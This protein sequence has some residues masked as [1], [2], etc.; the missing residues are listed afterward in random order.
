MSQTLK[1]T[2]VSVSIE[3]PPGE[4]YGFIANPENLPKWASG[5]GGRV[6]QSGSDWIVET[7]D[8]PTR[9]AFVEP[10]TFG[11]LDHTVY[12][13]P[14]QAILVPIRVVPNSS[15]SEVM[16]TVFRLSDMSDEEYARDIGVVERDLETLKRILEHH[17][18]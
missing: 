13:S 14:D 15:G 4:V 3:R 17:N 11:V 8:G 10:N 18:V 16:L 12:L 1:A 2:T 9:I 6:V 7:P 5:L